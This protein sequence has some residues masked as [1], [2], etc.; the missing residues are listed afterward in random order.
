MPRLL[1]WLDERSPDVVCL[2]ETKLADDAFTDLLGRGARQPRLRRS[3]PRRG[4]LERRRDPLARRPGG[5]GGRDP[6][7]ARLPR[8]RGTRRLRD[9]RRDPRG[10]GVR[11]ERAHARLGP[12]PVQARMAGRAQG[13]GRR[14][15]PGGGDRVRRHQHRAHRRRRVRPGCL[16]RRD[17]RDGA[18]AGRP[19]RPTVARP[20]RR[21]PRT[22]AGRA[23]VQLLGLPRR[24]VPPGPRHADRSAAGRRAGGR[25]RQGG[26]GGPAR[27]EGQGP[28]RSRAGDR[29]PG[30][31][32]RRRHRPRGAAALQSEAGARRGRSSR[33]PRRS[34]LGCSGPRW[35]GRGRRSVL[36]ADK[37][38][39]DAASACTE[40]PRERTT[41][42]EPATS[43]LG[44]LRSTN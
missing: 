14:R 4:G 8:A 12:L 39:E 34:A 31:G 21:R 29:G 7:R 10:L 18:R 41:G 5:R 17:P 40:R 27:P 28:Q 44:S 32:A 19:R 2:Q 1:A 20:S 37:P 13:D 6:R 36:P 3:A 24:H 43:S 15:R 16:R 22:L 25:P 23:R 33:S 35:Q 38:T 30:R 26:L 42:L 11:A 9:L